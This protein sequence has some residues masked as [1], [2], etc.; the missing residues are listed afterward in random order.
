[1]KVLNKRKGEERKVKNEREKEKALKINVFELITIYNCS[2][3]LKSFYCCPPNINTHT[4][5]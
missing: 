1:M 3:S 4:R 2:S 5:S